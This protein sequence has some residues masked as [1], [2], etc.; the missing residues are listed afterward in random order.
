MWVYKV[1]PPVTLLVLHPYSPVVLMSNQAHTFWNTLFM[2][3]VTCTVIVAC[4]RLYR[5][6]QKYLQ[7]ILNGKRYLSS[8]ERGE[9]TIQRAIV[10][11]GAFLWVKARNRCLK[12]AF[13]PHKS[14]W[15]QRMCHILT[16]THENRP[17]RVFIRV[18]PAIFQ[19]IL[20]SF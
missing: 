5:M 7:E 20:A 12:T 16:L 17:I 8:M 13:R 6:N 3:T 11:T 2:R 18:I 4:T 14:V 15:L 10:Q 9:R 1:T 19:V